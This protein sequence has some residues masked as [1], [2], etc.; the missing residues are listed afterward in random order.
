MKIKYIILLLTF[1]I[2]AMTNAD[3][4]KDVL[5]NKQDGL[6][7]DVEINL[8]N[9]FTDPKNQNLKR[10]LLEKKNLLRE[11]ILD[12]YSDLGIANDALK[13]GY[14]KS[15][16]FQQK[17]DFFKKK[18]LIEE[19]MTGVEENI[20]YPDF[21][22]FAKEQYSAQIEK[23]TI[24]EKRKVAH[25][26]IDREDKGVTNKCSCDTGIDSPEKISVD[27]LLKKIKAGED[28][29]E[30]AKKYST[31]KVSAKNGGVLPKYVDGTGTYIASFESASYRIPKVGDISRTVK[32]RFGI[33]IIKLLEII[34]SEKIP[35]EKVKGLIINQ[36]KEEFKATELGK[37]RS[38]NYPD[39]DK[40]DFDHIREIIEK[41]EPKK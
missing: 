16:E 13:Q 39:L 12:F 18:L 30:L 34:P 19:I 11:F 2:M 27:E 31:D 37:I 1:L 28:F 9:Y 38:R 25:I 24:P 23:Y 40:L 26:L 4:N 6:L 17:V 33:H 35:F 7:F 5:A 22:V 20:K 29:S 3:I 36:L 41:S 14:G 10:D 8:H 32:T 21:E 15:K